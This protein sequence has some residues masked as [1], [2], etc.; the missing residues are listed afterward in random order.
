MANVT[1]YHEFKRFADNRR[2]FAT[3]ELPSGK[4]KV[5]AP[6]AW[7]RWHAL[8]DKLLDPK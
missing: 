6:P 4:S 3:A 5:S 2:S 7:I 1:H 8:L